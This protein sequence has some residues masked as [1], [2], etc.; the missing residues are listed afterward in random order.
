MGFSLGVNRFSLKDRALVSLIISLLV[1]LLCFG[2]QLSLFGSCLL[3][4]QHQLTQLGVDTAP[5]HA[6]DAGKAQLNEEPCHLSSHMLNL[7]PVVLQLGLTALLLFLLLLNW[8]GSTRPFSVYLSHPIVSK[9]RRHSV[10]CVYL[11]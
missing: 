10:L 8:L 3:K 5:T 6:N 9:R 2:Q 4:A 11:E 1:I 7:Q